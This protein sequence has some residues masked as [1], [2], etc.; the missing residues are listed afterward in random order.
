MKKLYKNRYVMDKRTGMTYQLLSSEA[1]TNGR[2]WVRTSR[3]GKSYGNK[4]CAKCQVCESQLI[5]LNYI[6]G[7][8]AWK[9]ENIIRNKQ[10]RDTEDLAILDLHKQMLVAKGFSRGTV[11]ANFRGSC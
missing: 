2:R 8:I 3:K 6:E 7:V 4:S 11:E 10:F 5:P 9:A 1:T